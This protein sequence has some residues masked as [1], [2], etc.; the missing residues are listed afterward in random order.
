MTM[1]L[2]SSSERLLFC[3]SLMASSFEMALNSSLGEEAPAFGSAVELGVKVCFCLGDGAHDGKASQIT[4]LE[5]HGESARGCNLEASQRV[6]ARRLL[7]TRPGL[8]P[9]PSVSPA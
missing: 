5:Q 2:S 9:R 7:A 8:F 3:L 4:S 6:R 1:G